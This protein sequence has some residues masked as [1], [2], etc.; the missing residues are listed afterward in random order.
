MMHFF[1]TFSI[2]QAQRLIAIE[3]AGKYE[4][5]HLSKTFVKMARGGDAYP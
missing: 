4:K 2:M 3:E 1:R 5:L